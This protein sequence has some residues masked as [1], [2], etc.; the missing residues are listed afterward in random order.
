MS[1]ICAFGHIENKHNSYRGEDC[2]NKFFEY[3]REHAK[4]IIDSEK[5][6]MIPL[7]KEEL[8]SHHNAKVCYICKIFKISTIAHL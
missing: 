1:T 3:L 8:K 5:K 6:K 2:R 4:N 7:T